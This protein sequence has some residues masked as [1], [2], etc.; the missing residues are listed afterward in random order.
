MY[1]PNGT[2]LWIPE[3]TNNPRAFSVPDGTGYVKVQRCRQTGFAINNDRLIFP[4]PTADWTTSLGGYW[5]TP[6]YTADVGANASVATY[7]T[8]SQIGDQWCVAKIDDLEES[9]N[10]G[11]G[12]GPM[13]R[14]SFNSGTTL[15][16]YYGM[17]AK[18]GGVYRFEIG[19]FNNN[20]ITAQSTTSWNTGTDPL[21][22]TCLLLKV[23]GTSTH[24]TP[25]G[26]GISVEL[27]KGLY[28]DFL[29]DPSL[30]T[31][32][33][34]FTDNPNNSWYNTGIP[35]ALGSSGSAAPAH[36]IATQS[37]WLAGEIGG[38]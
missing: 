21:T 4:A 18:L 34:S 19:V 17:A 2:G 20:S 24:G 26:S 31:S 11:A 27:Y 12:S 10:Q 7:M 16:G 3:S 23:T 5:T 22:T 14:L 8:M 30:L 36:T 15:N 13:C 37:R 6:P 25:P 1:I 28:S 38:C 33:L 32:I 9:H 29:A 35:G